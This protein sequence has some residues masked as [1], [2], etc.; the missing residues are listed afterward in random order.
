M[1]KY[2][3]FI[4]EEV[5][6]KNISKLAKL[7]KTA[8]IYFHKDLDG[9]TS[10][11]AIKEFLKNYYQI[12]TVDSHV[13]QYGGLEYAIKNH[14][15]ENLSVLV[16]FAHGKPMFH[17]QSDHHDKQVGAE[18]TESTYF[19]S[20]RSNVEIIS[21]EI[22]YSDIFTDTDLQLIR[23][24][25]SADFFANDIKPEDVQNSI[26]KY[27]KGDSAKKN[28]T[29]MGFTVNRLLLAYK[30][31]R[32]SLKSLDGKRTHNNRNILE[33]L[34]LDSTASL[35]SMFNNIRHYINVAKTTDKLGRLAT[36]EE[37]K[38]NLSNYIDRMKNYSFVEDSYGRTHEISGDELNVLKNIKQ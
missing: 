19:K 5:G 31:K 34:L 21:G 32:I 20:A 10:A 6:M 15:P 3:E 22:S 30:N 4:N 37:I 8:E 23:T 35:Y 2:I 25:D 29:M 9:V 33:C 18:D 24:I 11:L 14:K 1:K 36:P 38:V 28:R 7:H 17:I 12:E 27:Q 13:I 16:D 26:F